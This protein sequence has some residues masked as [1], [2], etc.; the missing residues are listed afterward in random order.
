MNCG[1]IVRLEWCHVKEGLIYHAESPPP[2]LLQRVHT[3]R[4]DLPYNLPDIRPAC[5]DGCVGLGMTINIDCNDTGGFIILVCE[6]LG[7]SDLRFHVLSLAPFA[8]VVHKLS[9]SRIGW[10]AT[11]RYV[12]GRQRWRSVQHAASTRLG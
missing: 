4:H 12:T 5:L 1:G 10:H 8:R 2:T 3:I 9:P 11:Q 6:D 7:Q